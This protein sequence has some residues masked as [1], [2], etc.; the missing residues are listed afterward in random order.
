MMLRL[1]PHLVK[2]PLHDLPSVPFG[3]AFEPAFR[4]WIT[5]DRTA[6]GYIGTPAVASRD[7]GEILFERFTDDATA[8]LRRVL[9]W[10]GGSWDG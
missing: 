10:N 9:N 6:P 8:M 3:N 2:T 1:A 7:K 4:G 5:R